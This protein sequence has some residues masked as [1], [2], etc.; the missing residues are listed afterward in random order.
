M[1]RIHVTSDGLSGLDFTKLTQL[2]IPEPEN[3]FSAE[4]NNT[5]V[6]AFGNEQDAIDY[7]HQVD[8][9]AETLHNEKSE[10]LLAA[11]DIIKAIGDDE[12]VQAYIQS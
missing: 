3:G 5:V 7:A 10:E 2:H 9:Y 1:L 4:V 12:F 11:S 6:M 8:E